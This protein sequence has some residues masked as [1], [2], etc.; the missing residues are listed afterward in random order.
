MFSRTIIDNMPRGIACSTDAVRTESVMMSPVVA[1]TT[2]VP[3]TSRGRVTQSREVAMG[4]G[5][6][7]AVN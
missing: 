7:G 2:L 3:K 1:E 5:I 4:A 6:G